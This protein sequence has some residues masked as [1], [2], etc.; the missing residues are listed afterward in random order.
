MGRIAPV[1]ILILTPVNAMNSPELNNLLAFLVFATGIVLSYFPM[2][3]FSKLLWGCKLLS[4][5]KS[6]EFLEDF[7]G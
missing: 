3:P 4:G 7:I 2:G 1:A 6:E 5:R